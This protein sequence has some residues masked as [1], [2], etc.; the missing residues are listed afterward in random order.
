MKVV[1][2]RVLVEIKLSTTRSPLKSQKWLERKGDGT[3]QLPTHGVPVPETSSIQWA[4]SPTAQL[5]VTHLATASRG[6][7]T[8]AN[9]HEKHTTPT[10]MRS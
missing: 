4:V 10:L 7:T 9:G 5:V 8:H 1:R 3:S 2:G 6:P